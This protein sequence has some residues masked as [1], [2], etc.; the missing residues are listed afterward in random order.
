MGG[1]SIKCV[2]A[3]RAPCLPSFSVL[4]AYLRALLWGVG[5]GTR[6]RSE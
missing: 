5:K 6:K 2:R 3:R 1:A 4:V